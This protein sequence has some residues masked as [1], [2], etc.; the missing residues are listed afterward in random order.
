MIFAYKGFHENIASFAFS[1]AVK[2]SPVEMAESCKV[3]NAA[4]DHAFIGVCV[5][6][7]GE[8]A[9]VQLTGYT[10]LP[11]TG[12]APAV[13]ITQLAADGNGGVKTAA[14]GRSVTVL[15]TDTVNKTVGFIL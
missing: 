15:K 14:A 10:E 3:K 11:Y 8:I 13:G 5:N 6:T 1:D 4:A 9:G 7:D 12:T 2:G